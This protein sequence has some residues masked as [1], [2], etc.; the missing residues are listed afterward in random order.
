MKI[1]IAQ[2]NPKI[3]NLDHNYEL[4]NSRI[5][6]A[7]KEGCS[8]IV[9]PELALSGYPPKDLLHYPTFLQSCDALI[10]QLVKRVADLDIAVVCGHP[11]G[12]PGNCKNRATVFLAG[13]ILG[14]YDKHLLPNYDVFNESRYFERGTRP[15]VFSLMDKKI[16]VTICEDAWTHPSGNDPVSCSVNAG[17]QMIINISASPFE[18]SKNK[19]R[20]EVFS[21]HA[22]HHG[23]PLI[24]TNQVGANDG[25]IFDGHS[26]YMDCNGEICFQLPFCEEAS[27]TIPLQKK[28]ADFEQSPIERLYKALLLGIKEYVKKSGFSTVVIGLSGGIDSAVCAALA[29]AALGNENVIGVTMPSVFSSQGS[30]EDSKKL[31][32]NLAIECHCLP[33]T[34]M[35]D[36]TTQTLSKLFKGTVLNEA[37]ENIQSRLRGV[38]LM[39]LANKYGYL[40]LNTGN[41]SE[42]AVGYCT[43]YGDMNGA[44]SVLGDVYK[45]MV[46]TLAEF[47]NRETPMIPLSTLK[48]PPSAELRLDQKDS[49]SLPDYEVMDPIL[50]RMIEKRR[51]IDAIIDEGYP[52]KDVHH[53]AALLKKTEYKRS[54]APPVLKVSSVAFGD[55]WQ[56]PIV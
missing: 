56:M 19:Q 35:V 46:Y 20:N 53:I 17:A 12:V 10:E 16:G 29:V 47:I 31:A 30:I 4:I 34:S 28:C 24:M 41:K 48:K 22:K 54:Q 3:G 50:E 51:S 8:L 1:K 45:S 27:T 44:L 38:L 25:L 15:C 2:I 37:E 39:G 5:I 43:L 9:F 26:F 11:S 49:D 42:L 23:V 13:H 55:G 21:R 40:V 33:I 18:V 32:K 7:S 6:E 36:T 52:S 14:T